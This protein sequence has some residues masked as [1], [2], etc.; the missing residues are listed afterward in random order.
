M[1]YNPELFRAEGIDEFLSQMGLLLEQ[2][3]PLPS[4]PSSSP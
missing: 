4:L 2:V 3:P 1:E